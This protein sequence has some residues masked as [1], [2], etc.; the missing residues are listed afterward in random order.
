MKLPDDKTPVVPY[1]SPLD[2]QKRAFAALQEIEHLRSVNA[3]EH[4]QF[5]A[6][7]RS[8]SQDLQRATQ[9][10]QDATRWLKIASGVIALCTAISVA[11][12]TVASVYAKPSIERIVD[13]QMMFKAGEIQRSRAEELDM[14]AVRAATKAVNLVMMPQEKILSR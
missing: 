10:F 6:C 13:T 8:L 9:S 7:D 11:Y 1:T 5:R 3:A 4:Q 14:V 12:G 2:P